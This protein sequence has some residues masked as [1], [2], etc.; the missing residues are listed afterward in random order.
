MP[1][2][3]LK[4]SMVMGCVIAL[5][6]GASYA[7]KPAT[8]SKVSLP[9]DE[10]KTW[11]EAGRKTV[12]QARQTSPSRTKNVILFVGDGM[13]ITTVTAA[14]ILEGQQQKQPGEEHELSFEKFPYS[15]LSKTY[16]VNQQ[17]P[18]SAG[19]MTA[20]ITGVK[21]N[22]GVLSVDEHVQLGE[23]SKVPKHSLET[24]IEQAENLGM[25]TG[26]VTTTRVTHATPAACYAHT[27]HRDWEDDSQTNGDAVDIAK[28]LFEFSHGNGIEIVLGGGRKHFF[29]ETIADPEES[30]KHGQRKDGRDL[31]TEWIQKYPKGTYVWN[32]T[33]WDNINWS[34]TD[35]VLGLFNY[36]HMNYESER[37]S[38]KAGE[39]SLSD[40]TQ[41]A[42]QFLS[43]SPKGYVL[44]VEGGRIDLAH[45]EGKAHH[46]LTDTIE[47]AKAVQVAANLTSEKDTLIAVTADHSH[48]FTMGGYPVRGNPILGKVVEWDGK[49]PG[50]AVLV[51]DKQG[52]PYTT[53][54]YA[55]GVVGGKR[56]DLAHVDTEH[57]DYQQECLIPLTAETHGGED[58]GI[59]ARG[60][61]AK[62]FHGVV[63]QNVIY[64]VMR[65]ALGI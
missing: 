11:F 10:A 22:A 28:Q 65:Q 44:M 29:P 16:N 6:A 63:E 26:I 20:M 61:G 39:P 8:Y 46:A 36:S 9:S 33:G 21:T 47:F 55:N 15:A 43:P 42:I 13:G 27:S 34:K 32:K 4:K 19:T 50:K 1:F 17:V 52:L 40:M 14:R 38:D 48:V 24:L 30:D 18:D 57:S 58:V 2:F 56:S 64:H 59:H 37:S 54:Q 51:K 25:A 5:F 23:F 31:I 60:P 3:Q 12:T 35:R 7:A 49:E 62:W 41:K 53:L 45:H